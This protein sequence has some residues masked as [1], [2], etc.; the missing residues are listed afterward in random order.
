[1]KK[2][3]IVPILLLPVLLHAQGWTL[4]TTLRSDSTVLGIRGHGTYFDTT[5][6]T[7]TLDLVHGNVIF[8]C[9]DADNK[10][11]LAIPYDQGRVETTA[12][13]PRIPKGCI[14]YR[15]GGWGNI[16]YYPGAKPKVVRELS[17]PGPGAFHIEYFN[18]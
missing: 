12:D 4:K 18:K 2:I 1:M 10:S 9:T 8:T 7:I 13:D 3:I 14:C 5:S 17:M 6:F 15:T 11:A 16:I